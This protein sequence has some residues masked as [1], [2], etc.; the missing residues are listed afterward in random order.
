MNIHVYGIPPGTNVNKKV[1]I[2]K[3]AFI[4]FISLFYHRFYPNDTDACY[5]KYFSKA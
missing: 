5:E 3:I 2:R 1:S 4:T